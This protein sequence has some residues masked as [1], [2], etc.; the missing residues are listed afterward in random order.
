M[1]PP[2]SRALVRGACSNYIE[3]VTIDGTEYPVVDSEFWEEI[4]VAPGTDR[5]LVRVED[6]AGNTAGEWV[7]LGIPTAF[8]YLAVAVIIVF[9]VALVFAIVAMRR[10]KDAGR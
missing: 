5:I 4:E 1:R 2:P 10:S 8:W 3:N 6:P 7:D 9:I